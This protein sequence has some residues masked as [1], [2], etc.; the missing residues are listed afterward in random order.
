MGA[1]RPTLLRLAR[2]LSASV[3]IEIDRR[4]SQL[5]GR[6][7][8]RAPE[9]VVDPLRLQS[10]EAP[11][12][13]DGVRVVFDPSTF[14]L[15]RGSHRGR[16][17]IDLSQ[18]PA[19]WLLT[20]RISDLAIG[21]LLAALSGRDQRIEGTAS[22]EGTFRGRVGEPLDRVEGTSHVTV[23][24]GAIREF[25]LLAAINRALRLAEGDARDTRF[26]RLTATFALGDRQ[27]VTKDLVLVARDVR[28]EAAGRIG[29]DRSLDLAGQAALSPARTES[30]I[31]SVRE[32][33]GL[34]NARG[35]LEIPLTITG[36]A[37]HPSIAIDLQAAIARAFK[38]EL[39]RRLLGIIKR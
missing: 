31:R 28:V 39:R 4:R 25:P 2:P 29:F 1:T 21:E 17:T 10:I 11:F 16:F 24:N 13:T 38:E 35:E 26:E 14:Q 9:V 19:R 20:N 37:D 5:S 18:S 7:S 33:R 32:L 12:T 34:K 6:G 15:Y 3:S 27:A 23:V 30:A 8:V 36:T 22:T